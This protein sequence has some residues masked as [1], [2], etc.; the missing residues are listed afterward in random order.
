[1]FLAGHL[2]AAITEDFRWPIRRDV[3]RTAFLPERRSCP[4]F[5]SRHHRRKP[6]F[7]EMCRQVRISTSE[8]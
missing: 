7:D 1:M 3:V 4:Q 2:V 8:A 5:V 6:A